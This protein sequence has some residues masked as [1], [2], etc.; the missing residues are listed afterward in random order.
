MLAQRQNNNMYYKQNVVPNMNNYSV[1]PNSN[2]NQNNKS[3]NNQ[4]VDDELD[5]LRKLKQLLDEGVITKKEFEEKKKKI[6]DL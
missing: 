5:K 2:I 1:N 3:V 6:L 4:V